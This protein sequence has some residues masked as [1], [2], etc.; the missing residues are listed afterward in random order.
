ME[1][2][3]VKEEGGAKNLNLKWE[4]LRAGKLFCISSGA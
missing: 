3:G 1:R 2:G 4:E